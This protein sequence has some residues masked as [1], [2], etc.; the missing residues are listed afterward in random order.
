M[1]KNKF[2]YI[3][4]FCLIIFILGIILFTTGCK[5]EVK[6]YS[7]MERIIYK[8]ILTQKGDK[9]N[10]YFVIIYST[11]CTYC[12][13]LEDTVVKY[14]NFVLANKFFGY[15]CPPVYVLNI[16]ATDNKD[17]KKADN[18]YK[19]FIGTKNYEDVKFATAPAFIEVTDGEVTE[20]ISSK[21][22]NYPVTEVE[23]YLN[24]IM[25]EE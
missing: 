1:G 7:D 20:L 14:Q 4:K 10:K 6:S 9:N 23:N 22:T 15:N 21:V 16:N 5:K 11:T 25:N 12:E 18:E 24:K 17:I 2:V 8:D 19:N 13:D 3:S